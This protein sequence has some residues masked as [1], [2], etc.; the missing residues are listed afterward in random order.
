MN[1]YCR[2]SVI[3]NKVR[4]QTLFLSCTYDIKVTHM[5]YKKL[6]IIP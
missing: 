1:K 6:E 2:A 4:E 3:L 5:I